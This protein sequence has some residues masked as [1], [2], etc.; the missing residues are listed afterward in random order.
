MAL[1]KLILSSDVGG[2]S[3]VII[4]NKT[5]IL[6]K[7]GDSQDLRENM[8]YLMNHNAYREELG[9]NALKNAVDNFSSSRVS[10]LIIEQYQKKL[11]E[12]A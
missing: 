8:E 10:R 11:N 1:K 7:R 12:H 4:D 3:E 2:T 6:V 9:S 5:G